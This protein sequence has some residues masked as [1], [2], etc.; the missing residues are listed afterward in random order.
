MIDNVIVAGYLLGILCLGLWAGRG[1]RNLRE[2][3]VVHR[4]YPALVIFATLSASF[5]GGGFSTGNASKV[6]SIG[7][8]SMFALWGFSVKEL[9]VATLIAPRMDAFNKHISVGDIMA[10]HYGRSAQ[11]LSGLLGMLV[12]AGIVGAQVGAMG[13]VF[14]QFAGISKEL[15]I[16]IGCGIVIA[17]TTVGGMRAIVLTDVVQFVVLSIG[18]PLALFIGLHQIGGVEGL[19]ERVPKSHVS[20][21]N[22]QMTPLMFASLFVSFLVGETLVPP[23]VQ[24]LLVGRNAR[25]TAQGTLYSGLFSIPFFAVTGMIGL[26]ALALNPDLE[27]NNL[28]MPYVIKTVLPVGLRGL[29]IAGIISIVMSSADSFL[30]SASVAL[31]NDVIRPFKRTRLPESRELFV[32]K[33]TT[34]LVGVTAVVF[35]LKIDNILDILLFSYNF[36]APIIVVPLSA[37]LLGVRASKK[38]FKVGAICGAFTVVLWNWVLLNPGGLDGLVMGTLANLLAFVC[39]HR[40]DRATELCEE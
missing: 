27:S 28:A 15:G 37:T 32:T 13:V 1:I 31:I 5:I 39:M 16:F 22:E 33:L 11:V 25:E 7:M 40:I 8:A 2:Y 19:L 34:L 4:A 9:L 30:N 3:S 26:V 18:L 20:L 38:T 17:Y 10:I 24:R 14:N 21:F 6:Y 29:V 36:W 12:C 35:A 23:Y